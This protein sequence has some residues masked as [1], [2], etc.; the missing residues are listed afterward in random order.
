MCGWLCGASWRAAL[1]TA[2][3]G[4]QA[5]DV[6][7][8]RPQPRPG[9]A[10]GSGHSRMLVRAGLCAAPAFSWQQPSCALL[11]VVVARISPGCLGCIP[12]RHCRPG[13][14]GCALHLPA[15]A[16]N[17]RVV[18]VAR[19]PVCSPPGTGDCV[20]ADA[21]GERPGIACFVS[22]RELAM[23]LQQLT[24]SASNRWGPFGG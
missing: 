3:V 4:E 22:C 5:A 15:A 19:A 11:F 2:A 8:C 20:S 6:R 18:R 10:L 16:T 13:S 24:G 9:W 1:T 21:V 14:V 7:V 12:A 17:S 23:L